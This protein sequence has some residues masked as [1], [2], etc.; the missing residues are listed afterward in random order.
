MKIGKLKIENYLL[1]LL[2]PA[3]LLSW[4]GEARAD[5]T[6]F[7]VPFASDL[8]SFSYVS[9]TCTGG[10]TCTQGHTAADGNPAG[11]LYV[12]VQGKN[13]TNAG[14]FHRALTWEDMGAPAGATVTQVNGYFDYRHVTDSH[15]VTGYPLL[16]LKIY[17]SAE[18]IS[19]ME[20][21]G[22]PV[23]LETE[24][25]PGGVS[26]SW[27]TRDT[28]GNR[29][30]NSSYQASD[31]TVNLR[32]RMDT[33]AGNNNGADSQVR[34]DQLVFVITY[35]PAPTG[36]TVSGTLY[37]NDGSSVFDCLGAN[38]TIALRVNGADSYSTTC[39]AADGTWSI[40]AVSLDSAGQVITIWSD[41]AGDNAATVTKNADDTSD[42][43]GLAL[44]Q[45]HVIV[46]QEGSATSTTN[47]NLG[48]YDSD[49]D[50]E[51]PF[52]ANSGELRLRSDTKL[53]VWYEKSF[54]PG[55]M[56]VTATSTTA[57]LPDG[58]LQIGGSATLNMG[59]NQL[60]VGGDFSAT[61][62]LATLTLSSGQN[63]YFTATS[64]AFAVNASNG[65]NFENLTFVGT[66][67][68]WQPSATLTVNRNLNIA[69][70][71]LDLNAND[72]NITISGDLI[73]TGTLS[74]SG[75]GTFTLVGDLQNSGAFTHNNGTITLA[76]TSTSVIYGPTT[77]YNFTSTVPKRTLQFE[78][79]GSPV[80][81]FAGT[82][83][84][85]GT[86]GNPIDIFS[87]SPGTQWK[88]HFDLAQTSVTYA[89]IKDS[90]CDAGTAS[91]TAQQTVPDLGNNDTCWIFTR[92]PRGGEKGGGS[93]DP[94]GTVPPGNGP[95]HTGGDDGGDGDGG[96]PDPTGT[97]PPGDG[98]QQT[99]GDTS[100]DPA[101]SP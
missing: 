13:K 74:A 86:S 23:D 9:E 38:R 66:G 63:T 92:N 95:Q 99:G 40:A 89:R 83:T 91:V 47:L 53:F 36:V 20:S 26:A 100:T 79:S 22:V 33:R 10:G 94:T 76:P 6:T 60:W 25:D 24:F 78:T 96:S 28:D 90:G 64:T 81:T 49:N 2:A 61:S 1:L 52:S 93:P 88:A 31:T 48:E 101:P 46:R 67:G 71:I 65:E 19:I 32:V 54:T 87:D 68:S 72:P 80:F 82:F 73:I 97:T 21:S 57:S 27:A 55:G 17:N 43:I 37:Q 7:T 85:A 12:R 44:Y 56:V 59:S 34:M 29:D 11:S 77:F 5:E 15:A 58:D 98:E 35:T 14:Y 84:I 75:S 62:T 51:I 4:P 45:N 16:G 69:A 18:T 3:F 42:I 8:E 70:G 30:V 50:P 39:S 41:S